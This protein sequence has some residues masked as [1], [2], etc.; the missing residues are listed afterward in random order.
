MISKIPDTSLFRNVSIIIA[1]INETISLRK[2][3]EIIYDTCD[4][5][6]IAEIILAISKK[7]TPECVEVCRELE[8][9][10]KVPFVVL[11]QKRPFAGGAYQDGFDVCHGSHVI[12]MASDMETDPR[13]VPDLIAAA[14]EHPGA[15]ICTSR[16]QRRGTFGKGYNPL[17]FVLNYIFQKLM[18]LIFRVN[19]TDWT[20][21]YRSFPLRVVEAIKWEEVRHP[22]FLESILTPLRLGVPTFE[23]STSWAPREEGVSQNPFW[24]NFL[25]FKTAFRIFFSNKTALLKPSTASD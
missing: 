5:N 9:E 21:G 23:I 1:A 19:L 2:T 8:R 11:I 13:S 18:R 3:V 14:R 10:A 16:W 7:S 24:R 25:Y 4:K 12:M 15:I 6:D 20:F 17:K 22:F